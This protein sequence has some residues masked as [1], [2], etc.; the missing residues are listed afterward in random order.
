MLKKLGFL[1]TFILLAALLAC[2]QPAPTTTSAAKPAQPGTSAAAV[3]KARIKVLASGAT[4]TGY[5]WAAARAVLAEK[6]SPGIV[7]DLIPTKGFVENAHMIAAGDAALGIAAESTLRE[8]QLGT[9]GFADLGPKNNYGHVI[10]GHLSIPHIIVTSNSPIK[11]FTAEELKGKTIAGREAGSIAATWLDAALKF[12]G[13]QP[14]KD[15]KVLYVN[16]RDGLDALGA[17]TA[18][19]FMNFLGMPNPA[20]E[21]FA[22]SKASRFIDMPKNLID[23]S[24]KEFSMVQIDIPAGTYKGMDK[25]AVSVNSPAWWFASNALSTDNVYEITRLWWQYAD[26]R[27]KI[28]PSIMKEAT[29]EALQKAAASSTTG[30]HAGALKYYKEKGWIK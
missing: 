13:L 17:G 14:G 2:S 4:S 29:V 24:F 30:I 18:H 1:M 16:Q 23:F 6:H 7:L 20:I 28:Q 19:I 21:E 22:A 11:S 10:S 3:N 15:I 12:L 9:G 5:T 25:P 8:T 27:N 26:E